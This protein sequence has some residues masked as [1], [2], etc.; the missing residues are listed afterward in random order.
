MATGWV[1]R[2]NPAMEF[3]IV[4]VILGVLTGVVGHVKGRSMIVWTCIGLLFGCIGLIIALCV[5]SN[6][7][8]RILRRRRI[9]VR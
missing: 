1:K 4:W 2:Y 8:V 7:P 3:I 5:S 6:R 9:R